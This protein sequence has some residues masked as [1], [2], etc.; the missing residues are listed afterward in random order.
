M[1]SI[2][3]SVGQIVPYIFNDN[4][5]SLKMSMGCWTIIPSCHRKTSP[6]EFIPSG[7]G[8]LV[9]YSNQSMN[10]WVL[11]TA[12]V[13][14]GHGKKKLLWAWASFSAD[15]SS[16][17]RN[18]MYTVMRINTRGHIYIILAHDHLR[19]VTSTRNSVSEKRS[20]KNEKKTLH[21]VD[22]H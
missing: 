14:A 19:N 15:H 22:S 2:F 16:V 18:C 5:F 10:Q 6:S 12:S 9:N 21:T 1:L 7:V 17:C 11:F 13:C 4:N 8:C 20:E 3:Y